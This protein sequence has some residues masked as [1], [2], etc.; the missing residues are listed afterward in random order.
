MHEKTSSMVEFLERV[1]C[2]DLQRFLQVPLSTFVGYLLCA[3]D[4][5]AFPIL[6]LHYF[7]DQPFS[8]HVIALVMKSCSAGRLRE[9]ISY[10]TSCSC[11]I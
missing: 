9:D 2:T 6:L 11:F 4:V 10:P 8:P 7:L 3:F 5:T 1:R